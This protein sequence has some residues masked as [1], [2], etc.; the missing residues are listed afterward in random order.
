[1]GGTAEASGLESNQE[2][3]EAGVFTEL[4]YH[5]GLEADLEHLFVEA[6][7]Q[8]EGINANSHNNSECSA[9]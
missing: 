4:H 2:P 6:E 9:P 8:T 1:M 3:T 5:L 7:T